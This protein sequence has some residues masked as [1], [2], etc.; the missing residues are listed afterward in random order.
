MKQYSLFGGGEAARQFVALI[1]REK[2]DRIYD[3]D[4]RKWETTVEGI[5][6]CKPPV[7]YKDVEDTILV[8]CVS[9]KYQKEIIAQV[10]ALGI[11]NYVTFQDIMVRMTK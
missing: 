5:K 9:P 7:S 2:I 4:N 1:G 6:L 11:H 10:E 8:I 3:N